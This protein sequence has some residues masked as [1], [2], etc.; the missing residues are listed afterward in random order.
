M[1]EQTGEL[2]APVE[3]ESGVVKRV[4]EKV[5]RFL[6]ENYTLKGAKARELRALDTVVGHFTPEQQMEMRSHFEAKAEKNAK[7]KVIRNWVATGAGIALGGAV[8]IA[9]PDKAAAAVVLAAGK[10]AEWWT[11]RAAPALAKA[12]AAIAAPFAVAGEAIKTGANKLWTTVYNYVDYMFDMKP[13]AVDIPWTQIKDGVPKI[14]PFPKLPP[15]N[16]PK[17][18]IPW[19]KFGI[20]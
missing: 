8:V 11:A 3:R 4:A 12:G 17:I 20:K 5:G 15:F 16:P 13:F 1:T 19:P 7:W 18:E 9:G 2:A 10:V 6:S 14:P